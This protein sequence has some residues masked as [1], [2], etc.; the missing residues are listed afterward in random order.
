M[1]NAGPWKTSNDDTNTMF[2]N[3]FEDPGKF[4]IDKLPTDEGIDNIDEDE[5][6]DKVVLE[7]DSIE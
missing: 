7:G 2:K 6:V 1:S 3:T 4:P 5:N